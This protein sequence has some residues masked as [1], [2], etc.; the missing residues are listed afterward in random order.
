MLKGFSSLSPRT[1]E[2]VPR[3]TSDLRKALGIILPI[4]V[5]RFLDII[6]VSFG[7]AY[8]KYATDHGVMNRAF[9]GANS[10]LITVIIKVV[11]LYVAT[12][13][14]ISMFLSEKPRL[15]IKRAPIRWYVLSVLL[16]ISGA[17]FVNQ[18]FYR[19]G[20]LGQSTSYSAIAAKQFALSAS[21]GVLV[22][23][24]LTPLAEEILYRG[25][26]YNRVRR[27]FNLILA[28]IFSALV[29]G[30]M[31]GNM[32]QAVYGS[33]LGLL[34]AWV[35]ERFGGFI[36]PY[37]IHASAN[38]CIYLLMQTEDFKMMMMSNLSIVLT[39]ISLIIVI[40]LIWFEKELKADK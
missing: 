18:I 36:F 10:Q 4:F 27:N 39:G 9:V 1:K 38:T 26:V 8:T 7:A 22:Y 13:S 24:L 12:G 32:V 34:I 17:L 23:G 5:F 6:I 29:F 3:E 14:V 15:F 21:L 30:I 11:A 2:D 16:G 19:L 33:I 25:I 35:Y 28:F 40:C 31:H 37:L 20:L